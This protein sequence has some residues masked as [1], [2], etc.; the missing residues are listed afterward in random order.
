MTEATAERIED[1]LSFINARHR[2]YLARREGGPKPW[3]DNPILQNYRF[4]NVYRELD[5]VTI[6]IRENIRERWEGH[7]DLWFLLALA[8]RINW[9]DTLAE[10]FA[11]G[12]VWKRDKYDPERLRLLLDART[13]RK[14]KVYTGAYMVTAEHVIGE[15]KS[16]ATAYSNLGRLWDKRQQVRWAN[17]KGD[18]LQEVYNQILGGGFAW[19]SFMAAQVIADLKYDVNY[20]KKEDWFDFVASGPG[21]RRGLNRLLENDLAAPFTEDDFKHCLGVLSTE[22][23]EDFTATRGWE[24]LHYQDIQNCLCEFDKYERVRLGEGRPRSRYKGGA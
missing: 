15:T 9:P 5:T 10:I 21:S 8:R 17:E 13:V 7:R 4:C 23:A 3:T 2:I 18:T 16:R 12:K 11:D 1:F 6:W 20:R 19:G 14:E 24:P 22:Y